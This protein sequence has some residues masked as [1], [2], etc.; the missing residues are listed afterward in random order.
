MPSDPA[1]ITK[2]LTHQEMMETVASIFDRKAAE[3]FVI[4]TQ[5]EQDYL[6]APGLARPFVT[7]RLKYATFIAEEASKQRPG[8][9]VTTLDYAIKKLM[10]R[11]EL[12]AREN[13]KRRKARRGNR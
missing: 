10:L 1:D 9:H 4:M 7:N 8:C 12:K 6:P 3:L 2:P 13:E 5:D 11:D